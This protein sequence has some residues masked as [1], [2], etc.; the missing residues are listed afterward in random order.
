MRRIIF[1]HSIRAHTKQ[2]HI[3]RIEVSPSIAERS[4]SCQSGI[5]PN[6][7]Q[8]SKTSPIFND[9]FLLHLL[10]TAE[11]CR[12]GSDPRGRS[13]GIVPALAQTRIL[14]FAPMLFVGLLYSPSPPNASVCPYPPV[15]VFSA[16]LTQSTAAVS[17]LLPFLVLW[18]YKCNRFLE[19]KHQPIPTF[20]LSGS[21]AAATHRLSLQFFSMPFLLC[22][23]AL[24]GRADGGNSRG[25]RFPI[26]NTTNIVKEVEML[27]RY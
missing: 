11:K 16:D 20:T 13:N 26:Q 4:H 23:T 1:V 27:S 7:E 8:S 25:V 17:S 21:H 9:P 3:V 19:A 22:F 2:L 10:P 24:R 18:T 14:R 12:R 5:R 6:C 15:F